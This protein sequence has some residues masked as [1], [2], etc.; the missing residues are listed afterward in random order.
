MP[1][2]S[3][4]VPQT[5][6]RDRTAHS[7]S[8]PHISPIHRS[9]NSISS[10]HERLLPRAHPIGLAPSRS[11]PALVPAGQ[12]PRLTPDRSALTRSSTT[13]QDAVVIVALGINCGPLRCP[14]GTKSRCFLLGRRRRGACWATCMVGR[15]PSGQKILV[16]ESLLCRSDVRGT[17]PRWRHVTRVSLAHKPSFDSCAPSMVSRADHKDAPSQPQRAKKGSQA[18]VSG[19]TVQRLQHPCFLPYFKSPRRYSKQSH[20]S[21]PYELHCHGRLA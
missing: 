5:R 12:S 20:T 9:L 6:T 17:R 15:L 10:S 13:S 8:S 1:A 16:A 18:R 2:A 11:L 19:G 7:N 21:S 14:L 3:A 4:V